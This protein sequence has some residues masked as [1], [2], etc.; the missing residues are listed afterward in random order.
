MCLIQQPKIPS[1]TSPDPT[2]AADAAAQ[3]EMEKRRQ[4]QGYGST[5]YGGALQQQPSLARK[6]LYGD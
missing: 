3:A 2:A 1:A 4:A 5:I 6:Q